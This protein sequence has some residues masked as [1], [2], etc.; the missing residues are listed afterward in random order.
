MEKLPA[1]DDHFRGLLDQSKG[2]LYA[3]N[4]AVKLI[5]DHTEEATEASLFARGVKNA[6]EPPGAER[7]YQADENWPQ[8]LGPPDLTRVGPPPISPHLL[9]MLGL[10]DSEQRGQI[11]YPASRQGNVSGAT[12][13]VPPPGR[14]WTR[15][16]FAT[17][18]SADR[19]PPTT[20]ARPAMSTATPS[21]V[22]AS[23]PPR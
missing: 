19:V 9:S 5:F 17:G 13:Q 3:K 18:K 16:A 12:P 8:G 14:G 1:W 11:G 20:C 22:S 15:K 4:K 21:A 2:G 23:D 7:V 6:D 10:I